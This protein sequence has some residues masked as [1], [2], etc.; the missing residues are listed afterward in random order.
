MLALVALLLASPLPARADDAAARAAFRKGVDLYDNKRWAEALEQFQAAYREKPSAII[1]Q[2]IGLCHAKLDHAVEAATAFDEA[3]EEGA[4]TLDRG[5]KNAIGAELRDLELRVA[6][7][8]LRVVDTT[9][10][11]VDDVV[12]SVDGKPL[13]PG[14]HTR[15][16]RLEPGTHEIA[17]RAPGFSDPPTKKL[18]LLQGSPVDATFELARPAVIEQLPPP[19]SGTASSPKEAPGAYAYEGAE[20]KPPPRP[21]RFL[22]AV[23]LALGG[24]SLRLGEGAGEQPGGARR[25]FFGASLGVRGGVQ[26]AKPLTV[27]LRLE[28]GSVT[29]RYQMDPGIPRDTK[30]TVTH[31]QLT[32]MLRLATPG[33]TRFTVG[34]GF[35]LHATTV[36]SEIARQG[37]TERR[38]GKGLA[39]SWLIDAGAQF[40]VGPVFLEAVAFAEVHGVSNARDNVVFDRMLLASPAV[41][42]G[43][44]GGVVVPF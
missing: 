20:R 30:Q 28:T 19:S 2:N 24:E 14:A 32:P 27:E 39:A 34:T 15:P 18:S 9:G 10:A 21:K 1:K 23:T 33:K 35:G 41:R 17:A 6:T 36:A 29:S 12:V 7:L 22:V 40:E 25:P 3:L 11:R 31:L 4:K 16:V 37:S 26:I 42:Y 44:R 13:P 8:R 38:E 43:A 5:T